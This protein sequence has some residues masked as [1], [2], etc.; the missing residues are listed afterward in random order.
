MKWKGKQCSLRKVFPTSWRDDFTRVYHFTRA[1]VRSNAQ[2]SRHKVRIFEKRGWNIFAW[3]G[4]LFICLH[5]LSFSAVSH[6]FRRVSF[7]FFPLFFLFL[8]FPLFTIN[9]IERAK[10]TLCNEVG[11][12]KIGRWRFENP[13]ENYW[14][15]SDNTRMTFP[16]SPSRRKIEIDWCLYEGERQT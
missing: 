1:L 4:F 6:A 3:R 16:I 14:N 10:W 7:V 12:I 13:F 8:I 11:G 15:R 2:K 9:G 5:F